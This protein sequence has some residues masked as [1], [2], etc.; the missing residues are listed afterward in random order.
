MPNAGSRRG[1]RPYAPGGMAVPAMMARAC[2]ALG[3]IF[4]FLSLGSVDNRNGVVCHAGPIP[5]GARSEQNVAQGSLS[6]LAAF[7]APDR[8]CRRT[9]RTAGP[10]SGPCATSLCHGRPGHA[11]ARA[12]RPCPS[13]QDAPSTSTRGAP[14]LPTEPT[15]RVH[16]Y[17]GDRAKPRSA[18]FFILVNVDITVWSRGQL[19]A[20]RG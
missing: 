12:G 16:A 19:A 18:R 7:P 15:V 5:V 14:Q 20:R 3:P 17:S 2:K 6:S 10:E 8:M 1:G 13:G 4:L 9:G 11:L